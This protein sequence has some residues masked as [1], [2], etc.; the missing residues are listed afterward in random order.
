[1]P[2]NKTVKDFIRRY[3]ATTASSEKDVSKPEEKVPQ[4]VVKAEK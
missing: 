1:L 3:K 2:P 4:E